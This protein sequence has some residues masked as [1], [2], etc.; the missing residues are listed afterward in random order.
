MSSPK[1]PQTQILGEQHEVGKQMRARSAAR[2]GI[3]HMEPQAP[4]NIAFKCRL[5]RAA[6]QPAKIS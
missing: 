1:S 3:A 2:G 5:S 6:L 4:L